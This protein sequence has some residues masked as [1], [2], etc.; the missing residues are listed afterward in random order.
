MD[1]H[2]AK[3]LIKN[4]FDLPFDEGRFRT[5]VINLLNEIDERKSFNYL[6]GTYIRHSYKP[7]IAKYRR[8]GT[9]TDPNGEKIDLL[10]VKL[11]ND[12]ALERSRSMLRNFTADY[13]QNRGKKD[14]ALVAY[15]T[16]N[17]D[18]WR[19]SFIRMEYKREKTEKGTYKIKKE[20][21]PA[22]RYSFRV[23]K[24]EPNHTAQAQLVGILADDN[25]NPTLSELE[26]AFS[27]EAVTKQFYKDYRNLFENLWH[28]IDDILLKDTKIASEFKTKS[29]DTANFAKKLMGQIVF[30]YFLQ[31]KGWL[32]ITRD[33]K[34]DYGPWGSGPKDFMRRLFDK[35]FVQYKNFFNDVLEYLF[36]EALA[37]ER[38]GDV[39]SRF[40]CKI[41]FLNGG[42]FEPMND[43]NWQE[44]DI[45]ID[46]DIF[47]EVFDTFDRYNFT[48]REDEPL[49]KEVAVDPEMLGKVFENLL[50]ENLRKGK[51][52]YYTP[53]PIVHYMCQE[54]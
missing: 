48:V 54:S 35:S 36:Y 40:N 3:T 21:T 16:N 26:K 39:Y 1:F 53:R 34:G 27:V 28:E 7:H 12:W 6:T 41:P 49:E 29:I 19:F 20:I 51:G 11:K 9:Y 31:K 8:L 33:Q 15:Y 43:Y 46:N 18:D 10:I 45:C 37:T 38:P 22:R 42:L 52:A 32:G 17:P 2:S 30:L 50:P 44:T 47:K 14:A 13:L 24:N 5:F 25:Q 4:T 23:G